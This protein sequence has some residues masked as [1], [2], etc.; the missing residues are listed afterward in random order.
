[1]NTGTM[2]EIDADGEILNVWGID[3]IIREGITPGG[4][5]AGT[6]IVC[7]DCLFCGD[8]L[9]ANLPYKVSICEMCYVDGYL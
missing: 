5:D 4:T 1:M 2:H 8:A 6:L 3:E 7:P 9:G